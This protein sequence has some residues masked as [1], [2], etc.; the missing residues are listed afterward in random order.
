VARQTGGGVLVVVGTP[1][2]DVEDASPRLVRELAT[3]DVVAAEDTRRLLRLASSVGVTIK[4][5][6]VSYFAGN[7][8]ARTGDLVS[9]LAQ[10]ARVV[11]V[12]DA[13]MPSVSDPGYLLVSSAVDAGVRVTSVP[14]PSAALTALVL[15]ALPA[16]RFCFEGF[17]PRR[18]GERTRWLST[19]AAEQRTMVFFESRHR[20]ATTLRS[21]AEIFGGDRRAAICRELTKTHEEVRRGELGELVAWVDAEQPL[22]EITVVVAG[23]PAEAGSASVEDA[24]ALVAERV[25]AGMSR[26]DAIASA[27]HELGL[28]KRDVYSA[29]LAGPR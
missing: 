29:V 18:A 6:L 26:R 20:L 28:A 3:A 27:A 7:E 13:G 16:D 19:L 5:R 23:A 25:A 2:G 10:G 22:G 11:L 1:I 21:M 4:G 15:S 14:G 9:A 8:A 24:V 12:T 17:P